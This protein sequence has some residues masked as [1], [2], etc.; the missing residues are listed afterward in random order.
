MPRLFPSLLGFLSLCVLAG[1]SGPAVLNALTSRAGF[2]TI[3]DL[4]Y[5]PGERGTYDLYVPDNADTRT[6]VVVFFHG[7]SWDGGSKSLY[8]FVG[9]SLATAGFVVAIPNYRLYPKTVFPGFVEDG[10]RAVAAVARLASQ[11]GHGLPAGRHPLF[12]MG[13]SAGA[14]IGALLAFDGRYLQR[15]GLD[16]RAL[17]GFIGLAG[18]YD[19]L[20][21]QEERY[22]RIF[23]P[24]VRADSQPVRFASGRA[25]PALLITGLADTTVEPKETQSMAR[26]IREK[27]GQVEVRTYPGLDHVGAVSSLATALPLG[28]RDVRDSVIRFVKDHS[29]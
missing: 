1:C 11:G 15:V 22:K 26:A 3:R 29:R 9:Q 6:P 20:P 27:G 23:P 8:P 2:E 21:I 4:R 18:P 25:A 28:N 13:H 14:Q 24:A 7:G 12:V 5:A 16:A 17:S 10:A 19:F